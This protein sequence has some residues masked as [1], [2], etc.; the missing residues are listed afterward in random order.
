MCYMGKIAQYGVQNFSFRF[1]ETTIRY[2]TGPCY[3]YSAK[4]GPVRSILKN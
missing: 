4:L 3:F 2:Q 1:A